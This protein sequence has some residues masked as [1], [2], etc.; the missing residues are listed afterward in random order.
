LPDQLLVSAQGGPGAQRCYIELA[1][2]RAE[3]D[4][5]QNNKSIDRRCDAAGPIEAGGVPQSC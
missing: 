2:Q 1:V 5:A 3:P 4:A